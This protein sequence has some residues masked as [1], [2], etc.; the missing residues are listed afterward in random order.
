M[1]IYYRRSSN[2]AIYLRMAD[3][4]RMASIAIWI[5]IVL[6]AFAFAAAGVLKLVG[7]YRGPELDMTKY[8]GATGLLGQQL[9]AP[10]TVEGW[11]TDDE[12][13]D[14]GTLKERVNF[15][16]DEVGDP[17]K[18]GIS[19]IVDLLSAEASASGGLP[20]ERFLERCLEL[21]GPLSV[22]DKTRN[23]LLKYAESGGDLSFT[24][25]DES[26]S[27]VVRMVQFIVATMEYQYA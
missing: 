26:E 16:D 27:R 1:F 4:S 25:E 19:S 15:A 22:G 13:I 23:T 9:L 21:V 14:S 17:P 20:P 12:W 3:S 24:R 8:G 18:P 2:Y 6:A 5:L 11:H 7:T 10:P